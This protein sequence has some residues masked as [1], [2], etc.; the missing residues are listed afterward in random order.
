MKSVRG[1]CSNNRPSLSS[2]PFP[3]LQTGKSALSASTHRSN[4]G[5]RILASL[6]KWHRNNHVS[7]KDVSPFVVSYN[8]L[9]AA[10][11]CKSQLIFLN[12]T[13]ELTFP[14]PHNNKEIMNL[15]EI[16]C[17]SLEF[18]DS[19]LRFEK[20]SEHFRLLLDK[21]KLTS[22]I[23]CTQIC[24]YFLKIKKNDYKMFNITKR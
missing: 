6:V 10:S 21:W 15:K 12:C 1:L 9:Y 5:L 16:T 8:G 4:L 19:R 24:M 3:C 18:R 20:D 11:F 22:D 2:H 14:I 13:W 7:G 23:F 17:S